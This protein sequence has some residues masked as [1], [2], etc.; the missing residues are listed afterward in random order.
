MFESNLEISLSPRSL[1]V[2]LAMGGILLTETCLVV[3]EF[4]RQSVLC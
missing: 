4:D 1:Q 2:F 3:D